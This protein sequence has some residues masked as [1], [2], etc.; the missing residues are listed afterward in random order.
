MVASPLTYPACIEVF[1]DDGELFPLLV[2]EASDE[3]I[4]DGI[5][6]L[7]ER[8]SAIDE[9]IHGLRALLASRRGELPEPSMVTFIRQALAKREPLT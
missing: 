3:A 6:I 2:E 1:G 9:D 8:R 7:V 4:E 5:K